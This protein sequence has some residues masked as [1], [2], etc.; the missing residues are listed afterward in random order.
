[1]NYTI[2]NI[3][4]KDY[5]EIE[6]KIREV[7]W[8]RY[9]EGCDEHVAFHNIVSHKD[10]IPELSF[11]LEVNNEIVGSIVYSHSKVINE[12]EQFNTIT[13]GPV[14]ILEKYQGK[15]LGRALIVHSIEE[16]KKLNYSGIVICGYPYHYKPYGFVGGKKY[17]ISMEDG[18][19]YTGIMALPLYDG[20]LN[21]V[22]G[23]IK[24]SD[25][26]NLKPEEVEQY[27]KNFPK[28]EKMWQPS[29]DEFL[30]AVSEIDTTTY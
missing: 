29:H 1:M 14:S 11:V 20:A 16:A 10:F 26:F 25:A 3:E 18:N 9:F 8:N 24:F 21:N 23:Y 5:I 28:K 7:F 27:D 6:T 2:R 4:K 15:G 30:K 13:F 12:K 17:N 22:K 19:F